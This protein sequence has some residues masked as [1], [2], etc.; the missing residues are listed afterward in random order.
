MTRRKVIDGI[1]AVVIAIALWAYVINVVNPPDTK[2]IRDIPVSIYG[3]ETLSR[4]KLAIAGEPDYTVDVVVGGSRAELVGITADNITASADISAL[5]AGQNYINVSV[6]IPD[7]LTLEDVRSQKIQVYVDEMVI[8]EKPLH[9]VYG[10]AADGY[11]PTIL[12]YDSDFVSVSGAKSL[13]DMVS[14]V[15]VDLDV[16]ELAIDA[17]RT[18]RLEG[19]PLDAEGNIV[20]AV[21]LPTEGI[22]VTAVIYPLKTVPLEVTTMGFPAYHSSI[23]SIE[24]PDTITI[25][26]STSRLESIY[27]IMAQALEVDGLLEDTTF[28]LVP[29]FPTNVYPADNCRE[30]TASVSLSNVGVRSFSYSLSELEIDGMSEENEL[31]IEDGSDVRITVTAHAT[32][33]VLDQLRK[34][35]VKPLIDLNFL[36]PGEHDVAVESTY[37]NGDVSFD[38]APSI[39]RI[40][41]VPPQPEEPEESEL[42][43][44]T[45]PAAIEDGEDQPA[46]EPPAA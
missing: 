35:E 34:S 32:L 29:K 31:V 12:R 9:I 33:S 20:N 22:G 40:N 43:E 25:K 46:E 17:P 39:L 38:F 27:N 37:Q 36:D 2:T 3:T 44:G 15:R 26:G 4:A 16:T 10:A 11:E 7:N 41:I 5:T 13:V 6:S 30:L 18:Q 14:E 21:K 8:E 23:R 1:I 19:L 45:T 28:D 24:A 42:T